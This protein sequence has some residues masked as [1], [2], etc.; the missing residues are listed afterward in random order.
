MFCGQIL[1]KCFEWSG[2]RNE[3]DYANIESAIQ[4]IKTLCDAIVEETVS[5]TPVPHA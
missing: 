1:D 3:K 2:G 4:K 5:P